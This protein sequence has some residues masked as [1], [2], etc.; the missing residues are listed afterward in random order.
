M[1]TLSCAFSSQV[2]TH[3]ILPARGR[4]GILAAVKQLE[5]VHSL[6]ASHPPTHSRTHPPTHFSNSKCKGLLLS[7]AD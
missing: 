7:A 6:L 1:S 5:D 3:V 4:A 2:T